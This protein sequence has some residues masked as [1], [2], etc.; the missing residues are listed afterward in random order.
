MI[1]LPSRR[2]GALLM[3]ALLCALALIVL[4]VS[5]A[6]AHDQV[7]AQSPA[8]NSHSESAPTEVSLTFTA[9]PLDLGMIVMIVDATDHDW[10]QGEP[11]VTGDTVTQ[12]TAGTLPDGYYEVRWRVVSSDGHPI[13][14]SFPFSVGSL[15]GAPALPTAS[16]A[17]PGEAATTATAEPAAIAEPGALSPGLRT[18]L[19]GAGGAV[20]AVLIFLSVRLWLR[21]T[22][23]TPTTTTT[24][25][26]S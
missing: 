19:Y 24:K 14:E 23:P 1:A 15:E 7:I 25:D 11:T 4:P 26:P 8:A 10:A 20:I 18:A 13:S 12:K 3:I 22:P 6:S 5:A 16:A 2:R 21:R 17:A 9:E